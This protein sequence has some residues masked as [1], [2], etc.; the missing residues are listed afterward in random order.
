MLGIVLSRIDFRIREQVVEP[1]RVARRP[2]LGGE[3]I[4]RPVLAQLADERVR[5]PLAGPRPGRSEKHHGRTFERTAGGAA[6]LTELLD[7]GPV[8]VIHPGLDLSLLSGPKLDEPARHDIG[9]LGLSSPERVVPVHERERDRTRDRR[10]L[11][12]EL[13]R[14][15]ERVATA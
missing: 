5:S 10:R 14:C 13:C 15:G 4:H 2:A 9:D 12:F 8:E 1:V 3:D 7:H 6:L 11:A